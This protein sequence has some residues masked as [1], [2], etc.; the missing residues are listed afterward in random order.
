MGDG[1]LRLDLAEKLD[2]YRGF[3]P[4]PDDILITSGSNHA[5]IL[6][7][8]TLLDPGDVVI[9]EEHSYAGAIG[10]IKGR[11][12]E[13]I[14]VSLDENGLSADHL[15]DILAAQKAKGGTP[16]FIYTIPT[17]QNPTSTVMPLDRRRKILDISRE[18]G[19]PV[20]GANVT[21]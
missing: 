20:R 16:K 13:L 18:H 5:L 12:A 6:L 4:S 9:C 8:Q 19:V 10:R 14:P 2:T 11:G 21:R 15:A 1:E 7:F 17:I 3:A